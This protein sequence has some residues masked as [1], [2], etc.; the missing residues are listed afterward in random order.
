MG[1][2]QCQVPSRFEGSFPN[3]LIDVKKVIAWVRENGE[4][5]GADPSALF[6]AGNSSG[7]HVASMPALT[8]NDQRFQPGFEDIDT[9]ITAGI[10][11]GSYYGSIAKKTIRV[12]RTLCHDRKIDFDYTF[13]VGNLNP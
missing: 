3:H 1:L 13:I 10:Y 11:Q 7:A 9:T 2:H 12:L 8:P 4:E 5:Y 6:W